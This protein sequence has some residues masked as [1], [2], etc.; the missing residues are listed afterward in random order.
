MRIK[1]LFC[2]VLALTASTGRA[3]LMDHSLQAIVFAAGRSTRFNAT[4]PK[5][6]MPINGKAMVSYPV[7]AATEL[8]IPVTVV[9][10]FHA[11]AIQK[12][13]KEEVPN[14]NITFALQEEQ[15]GTGHALQCTKSFWHADDILIMNGDHPLTSAPLLEYFI[16]AHQ[17]SGNEISILTAQAD[18]DC[19]YGRIIK[20]EGITRIVEKADFEKNPEDYPLVNAGFYLIKR[21]FLEKYIDKLWLHEN[22]NEYYITDLIEIAQREAITVNIVEVSFD[23]VYG[24]NTTTEFAKAEKLLRQKAY[25]KLPA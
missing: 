5:L 9:V 10:G 17:A 24:V 11:D 8:N 6:L 23:E 16:M 15:L 22:K 14:G 4:L 2:T 13:I 18:P 20:E 1:K 19:N 21:S 3:N 7:S 12:V 25:E